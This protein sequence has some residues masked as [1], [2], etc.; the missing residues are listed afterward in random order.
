MAPNVRD[1]SSHRPLTKFFGVNP[2]QAR[3]VQ[4]LL[5]LGVT[6]EDVKVAE[7]VMAG[8]AACDEVK[9]HVSEGLTGS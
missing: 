8:W 1:R 6:E 9:F 3:R 7:R 5:R 2:E 4:A